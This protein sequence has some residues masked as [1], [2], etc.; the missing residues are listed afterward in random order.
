MSYRNRI[1]TGLL[2][3]AVLVA[4][5]GSASDARTAQA[6][7][8][9]SRL[10]FLHAVAGAPE[11]D[12]YLDGVVVAS[13]LA[14]G[15]V[16][17]HLNVAGGDH[18]VALRQTGLGADAPAL[19]DGP[20][21]LT[22]GLA[23]MVVAQGAPGA[24]QAALYEDILD[25]I[26]LGTAR[27]AA[28]NAIP[29]APA[30][31]VVNVQNAP[32]LQGVMYGTPYGTV[33]HEV[34][35]QDLV[36]VPAG[37]AVESAVAT[38]GQV[39][40]A[41]GML[42]TFVAY[43]SLDGAAAPAAMVLASPVNGAA[44]SV[45][46]RFAHGSADAPAVDVYANDVLI[47]P[48]LSLG[49]MSAHLAFP[50]GD[51]TFALRPAGSPAADPT[52]ATAVVKLDAAAPAVTLAA[53][54]LMTD[55]T[56]SLELFPDNVA[57]ITPDKARIAV[58]NAVPGATVTVGLSDS[59]STVLASGLAS[60]AQGGSV[61]VAPGEYM[62]T[63]S[64]QGIESPVDL[65]VPAGSYS[66]GMYYSVLVYGG[67]AAPFDA[68][69][70]GTE[71]NVTVDSLPKPAAP[72]AAAPTPEPTLEPTQETVQ[73]PTPAPTTEVVAVQPT[74]V[75][76]EV[77][78][79][80][81]EP[82]VTTA[83]DT[84]L[85]AA[86]PAGVTETA[87]QPLVPAVANPVAYVEL[88]PGANLQCRELPGS[89]KRSLGLIPSGSTLTVLGRTG[90]PLVPETGAVTPEPTPEVL[91]IEELWLSVQWE[92]QGGGFMR[93][94]VNAQ[95][96]RVEW[97][98][99]LLDTLEE[100]WE[101]PEEPFNRP[102]ESVGT[103]IAPPTPLFDAVLATVELEPGVS[104]QLRRF[105]ETKAESLA[106]VPAKAQLE[107]LGYAEVPSEG[108]VG[109][110]TDPNWVY[111]RYREE[112]GGATIGWVS[113]QYVSLSKL[114]RP[115]ELKDL[116]V[117]DASEGGYFEEPG[118]APV[119]PVELQDVVGVVNLNPGA[120]LNLRDRP[121]ADARVVVGIPSGGAMVLNGRNG[122]GS[123]VQAT[124]ESDAGD[125]EGW[126]AS[127]YLIITRGGQPFDIQALPIVTGETDAMTAQ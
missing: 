11:V 90:T 79:V 30:L 99:K 53:V 72:V 15:E 28:V 81:V 102:G 124:Y 2:V 82:T 120:N 111:V 21:A 77:V 85:V 123:W 27:L 59:A 32:K 122:D 12:V 95:F 126:V 52:V 119:I 68:R 117:V 66:G 110:P 61:D 31:D 8:T 25:E 93:C 23:Y 47:I 54:G 18:Q 100:L 125:L 22:P 106:L 70:A 108:L 71:I 50:A 51:Y 19:I 74:P 116:V 103:N 118:V 55:E 33:N 109:Q 121:A 9:L 24:V 94:W 87:P 114:G 107:V 10:R 101:L 14:F 13:G 64:I 97:K 96:L 34:S 67:A 43:G 46:V 38:I 49:Q 60:N 83:A 44:G 35:V 4:L 80:A 78:I 29:D 104:L 89:D 16:T 1:L 115:V 69:V 41:S 7:S 40:L 84:E 36:V 73:L 26:N 113:L 58:V 127:Q 3:V 98:G 37:G 62:V 112:T 6:Q 5:I 45:R 17:P 57:G 20:A 105:P 91:A 63:A 39:P 88:D 92:P 75:P 48:A 42:Y 86:P 76:T 56:L 65:I